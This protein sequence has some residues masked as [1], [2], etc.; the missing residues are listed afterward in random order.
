MSYSLKN[1]NFCLNRV[2]REAIIIGL[3]EQ[4]PKQNKQTETSFFRNTSLAVCLIEP[5]PTEV[6]F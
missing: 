6:V 2:S 1:K 5:V 3:D 4:N